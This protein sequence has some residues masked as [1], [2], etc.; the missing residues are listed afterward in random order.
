M[1]PRTQSSGDQRGLRYGG[2]NADCGQHAAGDVGTTAQF[3]ALGYRVGSM[4]PAGA[5][6]PDQAPAERNPLGF[7][8]A[9]AMIAALFVATPIPAG[10]NAVA[11]R[12]IYAAP[13]YM[14][15][16]YHFARIENPGNPMPAPHAVWLSQT[17]ANNPNPVVA[18]F[19]R[20][21]L[22]P[23]GMVETGYRAV[24]H[25]LRTQGLQS[26]VNNCGNYGAG[27]FFFCRFG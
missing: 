17:D 22:Q 18:T 21:S 20:F 1:F 23:G 12:E 27:A 2:G 24:Q 15:P 4:A 26:F 25:P 7:D 5:L 6:T 14:A 19:G 9:H 10:T 16:R 8:P 3:A 11:F 13:G